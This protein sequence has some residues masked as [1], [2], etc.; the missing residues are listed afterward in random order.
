MRQLCNV[1]F[2]GKCF[3]CFK[4]PEEDDILLFGMQCAEESHVWRKL[5][6]VDLILHFHFED[7]IHFG[8]LLQFNLIKDGEVFVGDLP[9]V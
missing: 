9:D 2:L 3:D 1:A 6:I 5:D 4:V 8:D 7:L